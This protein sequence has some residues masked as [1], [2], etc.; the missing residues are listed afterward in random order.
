VSQLAPAKPSDFL[1]N[2]DSDA[3]TTDSASQYLLFRGLDP[4]VSEVVIAKG[5]A[6]LYKSAEMAQVDSTG[7]S[8]KANSKIPTGSS[9]TLGA[10]QGSILRILLVRDRRTDESWRYGF[11]EFATPDVSQ[12][13][14]RYVDRVLQATSIKHCLARQYPCCVLDLDLDIC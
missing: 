12:P 3:S 1:N 8:K 2:G 9:G 4:S 13:R 11:V 10:R 7:K 14:T 5:A 6:K